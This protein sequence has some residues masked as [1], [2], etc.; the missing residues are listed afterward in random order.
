M[1]YSGNIR[2]LG[3]VTYKRQHSRKETT[4]LHLNCPHTVLML[5]GLNDSMQ[6]SKSTCYLALE[7]TQELMWSLLESTKSFTVLIT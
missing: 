6:L 7:G 2:S 5:Q 4:A 1:F 3:S